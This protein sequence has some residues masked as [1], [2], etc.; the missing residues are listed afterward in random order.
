[1]VVRV[2]NNGPDAALA[3]A[4]LRGAIGGGDGGLIVVSNVPTWG[5]FAS[6]IWTIPSLAVQEEVTLALR[7][8]LP[9]FGTRILVGRI[10][11]GAFPDPELSN[12]LVILRLGASSIPGDLIFEDGIEAISGLVLSAPKSEPRAFIGDASGVIEIQPSRLGVFAPP[13]A[14]PSVAPAEQESSVP[15]IPPN[16]SSDVERLGLPPRV[17]DGISDDRFEDE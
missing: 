15:L 16:P 6:G 9:L 17:L 13:S 1:V 14:L 2:K 12:N 3:S 7:L 10:V 5:S 11:P 4:N 8:R